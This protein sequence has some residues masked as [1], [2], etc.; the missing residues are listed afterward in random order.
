MSSHYAQLADW[1]NAMTEFVMVYR[2]I[3]AEN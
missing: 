1:S 3:P 2:N